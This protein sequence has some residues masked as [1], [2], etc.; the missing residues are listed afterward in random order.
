MKF[1]VV[2][3]AVVAI[4]SAGCD[5]PQVKTGAAKV[6]IGAKVAADGAA[7]IAK[8]GYEKTADATSQTVTTTKIHAALRAAEGL[9][10][11]GINVDTVKDT[12]YLEGEVPSEAQKVLAGSIA[13][14][15]AGTGYKVVNNLSVKN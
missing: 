7:D 14:N 5:D 13:M 11:S 4:L 12:V 6:A 3:L 15:I 1:G 2:V 9:D 8:K 10:D